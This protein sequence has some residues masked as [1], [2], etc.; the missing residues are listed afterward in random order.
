MGVLAYRVG[1]AVE[2]K[3]GKERSEWTDITKNGQTDLP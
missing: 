3:G 2:E 1:R